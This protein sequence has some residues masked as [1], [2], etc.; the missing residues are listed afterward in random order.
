M[1]PKVPLHRMAANCHQFASCSQDLTPPETRLY[2]TSY[3]CIYISK[4]MLPGNMHSYN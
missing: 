4:A 1:S 3:T 2:T